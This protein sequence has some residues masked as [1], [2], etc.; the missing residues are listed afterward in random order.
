MAT[1][2]SQIKRNQMSAIA[3][4]LL[5][6]TIVSSW[7]S[8][9]VLAA[10]DEISLLTCTAKCRKTIRMKKRKAYWMVNSRLLQLRKSTLY[11]DSLIT[12]VRIAYRRKIRKPTRLKILRHFIVNLTVGLL[13]REAADFMKLSRVR[14]QIRNRML[15]DHTMITWSA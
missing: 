5:L 8:L 15:C 10:R 12:I 13:I 14:D 6:A 1:A 2:M 3:A 7:S 9:S 4:F 11:V